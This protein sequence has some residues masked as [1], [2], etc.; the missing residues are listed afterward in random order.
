MV[1]PWKN[2][3]RICIR[4]LGTGSEKLKMKSLF[5]RDTFFPS[6]IIERNKLHSYFRS[7]ESFET[8]KKCILMLI[9]PKPNTIYNINNS[10]RIKNKASYETKNTN[11]S[12][13]S[14]DIAFKILWIRCAI[15]IITILPRFFFLS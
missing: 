2:L 8:F 3:S 14:I 7:S 5:V 6:A 15:A 1:F 9:R 10:F 12:P 11:W 4:I 13:K